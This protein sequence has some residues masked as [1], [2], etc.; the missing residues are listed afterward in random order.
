MDYSRDAVLAR[1]DDEFEAL[2]A[3]IDALPPERLDEPFAGAA[4][5]RNLRD[6]ITH[7]HAWHIL[8][9][10]WYAEGQSG[11]TPEIPADG[12]AWSQVAELNEDLRRQWQ[13]T[14]L[15]ELLPL[16]KASHQSLQADVALHTD[17]EL[18]DPVLTPWTQG[19]ALGEF[20]IECGGNHYQW[21]RATIAAGLGLA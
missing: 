11:G 15:A 8:F 14:S 1:N 7:L 13:Q 3:L 12:Y 21:A 18:S 6:V 10:G 17:A 5:D 20:A 4:R 19:A 2:M 9:E 16:L